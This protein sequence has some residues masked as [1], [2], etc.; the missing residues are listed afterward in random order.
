MNNPQ[1]ELN[2]AF[3]CTEKVLW[4]YLKN[5]DLSLLFKYGG[6]GHYRCVLD[7]KQNKESAESL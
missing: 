5:R 7:D 3:E 2:S 6:L 1:A 4:S